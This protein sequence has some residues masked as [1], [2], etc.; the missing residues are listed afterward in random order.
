MSPSTTS[1]PDP[2]TCIVIALE[3]AQKL[4]VVLSELRISR[5]D[6]VGETLTLDQLA[7]CFSDAL[8]QAHR[9]IA[10]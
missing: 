1:P 5:V 2:F 7:M 6:F 10:R 9:G 8:T 3:R 4:V